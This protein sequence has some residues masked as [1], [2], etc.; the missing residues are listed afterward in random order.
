MPTEIEKKFL[1]PYP[2]IKDTALGG[3]PRISFLNV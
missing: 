1:V 2:L 3:C